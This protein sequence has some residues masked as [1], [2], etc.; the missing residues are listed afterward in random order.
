M[1]FNLDLIINLLGQE[2]QIYIRKR[3]HII[4]F[5]L[6]ADENNRCGVRIKCF[7]RLYSYFIIYAEKTIC[8]EVRIPW[9]TLLVDF[10]AHQ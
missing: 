10:P 1:E 3:R 2:S 9:F 7:G 8:K 4:W 6:V 5:D